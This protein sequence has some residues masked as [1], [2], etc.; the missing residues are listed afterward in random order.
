MG[1]RREEERN[2]KIIRGLMKLPPNRMCINCNSLGPQYVCTNF[3]TFVCMTCS[4]I[5]REFTHRVKSVSMS[6]FTSQEVEALQDGGNQR[7]RE[8]Y[9]KDWD[10]QTQRLPSS[11]N[12]EKIREFIKNVYVDRRYAGGKNSNK[13]PRDAQGLKNHEDDTR[14]ASSYHSYS[15]SP[16]YDYQYEDRR[17][18]RQAGALSRKP[19]SDRGHHIARFSSFI[20]SPGRFSDQAFEDSFANE[21]SAPRASDYSVSSAGDPFRSGRDS[22]S[23][24]KESGFSS[25]TIQPTRA[26]LTEDPRHQVTNFFAD[27]NP[28]RNAEGVSHMQRTVS[29]VSTGSFDGNSTSFKSHDTRGIVD[30]SSEPRQAAE[31]HQDNKS[32]FEKSS[33]SMNYGGLDLFSNPESSAPPS[34]DLFDM[35]ASS[36]V[37]STE[38]IQPATAL[39]SS[40]QLPQT[41]PSIDLFA[42]IIEN[43][44][45][46]NMGVQ[47]HELS[48]PKNEGWATFD[49]PQPAVANPGM[50]NHYVAEVSR[51]REF[52]L[53]FDQSSTL[54]TSLPW[55][56]FEASPASSIPSPWQGGLLNVQAPTV[57]TNTQSWNAFEDFSGHIS[58]NGVEQNQSNVIE[59]QA[60]KP[61]VDADHISVIGV[62]EDFK[63][64]GIQGAA[65]HSGSFSSTAPSEFGV[66]VYAPPSML[67]VMG[68]NQS[69][70]SDPRSINPFDLPFDSDMEQSNMFFD[71]GSIQAALPNPESSSTF[72]AGVSEP[73]FPQNPVTPFIQ[74]A[75]QGGLAYVAGQSQSSQL[76]NTPAPEPVASIGG[77]PFA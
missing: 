33:V 26:V 38:V 54:N 66:T 74:A 41:A 64:Y 77:N 29:L 13:P 75:P 12:V 63:N 34:I 2:E 65:N 50:E 23:F 3:W 47:S 44:S 60:Y 17:Y 35:P 53:N 20:G 28:K 31:V 14:R 57:A 70:T 27:S 15:Q 52:S 18:G 37:P 45:T 48:V 71:M 9:L 55:P 16:P 10:M 32:T 4:G 69:H 72:I 67:P 61:S 40:H 30:V 56:T 73:W 11:S 43:S 58:Q 7:A 36:S 62:S 51:D 5:H 42:G 39:T 6:K 1:S 21:G 8:I 25:P 24:Q 68:E 46:A 22:P 19:G 49:T 76:P 59:V